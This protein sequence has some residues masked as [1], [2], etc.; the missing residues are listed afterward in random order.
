MQTT[1]KTISLRQADRLTRK[2]NK[3]FEAF[4]EGWDLIIWRPNG[5]GYIRRNGMFRNG[6]WGTHYRHEP[7]SNGR[8][9]V[10]RTIANTL[11]EGKVGPRTN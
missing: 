6:R 4:W 9:K 2:D 1:F 11:N 10:L 8:Y 5:E 3:G 7:D